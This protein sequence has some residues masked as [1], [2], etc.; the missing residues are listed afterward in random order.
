MPCVLLP[1]MET[2]AIMTQAGWDKIHEDG[3]L[4]TSRLAVEGG[5]LYR[6]A[7]AG[8][9]GA[10]AFVPAKS[11]ATATASGVSDHM[12]RPDD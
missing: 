4:T 8:E 9:A 3:G 12:P 6:I 5:W 10:V 2:G 1:Y 7:T 11:S